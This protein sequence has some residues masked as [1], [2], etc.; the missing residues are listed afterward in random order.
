METE[1]I[2]VPKFEGFEAFYGDPQSEESLCVLDGMGITLVPA[3]GYVDTQICYRKIKP[4]RITLELTGK[5]DRDIL[6]G[7]YLETDEG[8][9]IPFAKVFGYP[10]N[11]RIW[12]VVEEKI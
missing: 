11:F 12:R 8:L 6:E 10:E 9:L 1:K 5:S 4:K 2:D 3:N 7:E